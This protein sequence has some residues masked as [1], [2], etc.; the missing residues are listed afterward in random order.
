MVESTCV[1]GDYYI[2]SAWGAQADWV[3]NIEVHPEVT[4]QVPRVGAL[5]GTARRCTD[6]AT[7]RRIFQAFQRSPAMRPYLE[8]MGV[9]FDEESFTA[10]RERV[11]MVKVV[12][13]PILPLPPQTADWAWLWAAV[14]GILLLSRL[15][16][17][18]KSVR[19][20]QR[21]TS[22]FGKTDIH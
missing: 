19:N 9:A 17:R 13:Q 22:A 21:L 20:A 4:L 10:S 3:K 1:E 12:P 2:I 5:G 7:F 16:L 14:A 6:E 18:A 15:R 11:Y 8:R